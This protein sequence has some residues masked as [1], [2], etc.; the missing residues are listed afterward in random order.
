MIKKF[1]VYGRGHRSSETTSLV[2][3]I[4]CLHARPTKVRITSHYGCDRDVCDIGMGVED[5]T[6]GKTQALFAI[7]GD[8]AA[9][10][11]VK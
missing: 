11:K 2:P 1:S 8:G 4:L 7:Y 5:K 3:T 10:K 9:N 6:V